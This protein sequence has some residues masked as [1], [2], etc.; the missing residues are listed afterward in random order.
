MMV[1]KLVW[2]LDNTD[3]NFVRIAIV[4]NEAEFHHWVITFK[5]CFHIRNGVVLQ[6]FL[7][8]L[9]QDV[10]RICKINFQRTG[11]IRRSLHVLIGGYQRINAD[12]H[13]KPL[14]KAAKQ[15]K[16]FS[17]ILPSAHASLMAMG[18]EAAVVLPYR[19]MLL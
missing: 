13:V 12:A 11:I 10:K 2:Y 6:V 14:P 4:I 19:M 15:I 16:S 7:Y 5:M 1:L 3:N 18:I 9:L 17:L 8:F